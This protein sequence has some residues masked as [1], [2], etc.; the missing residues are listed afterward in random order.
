[1][2]KARANG[3]AFVTVKNSNHFGATAPYGFAASVAAMVLM[4]GT[5]ASPAM[6]PFGGRDLKMGN[7]PFGFAAPE[8]QRRALHPGHGY[9]HR[10]A[11]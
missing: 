4:C 1:M 3:I 2:T 11:R 8:A 5:S 10:C 6:A 7:N 9:E